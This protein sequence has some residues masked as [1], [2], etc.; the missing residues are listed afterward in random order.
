MRNYEKVSIYSEEIGNVNL[1]TD[2]LMHYEVQEY[3]SAQGGHILMLVRLDS[4]TYITD[5]LRNEYCS[6]NARSAAVARG[7]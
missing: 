5:V 7:L 2:G 1:L 3:H 6:E 4:N